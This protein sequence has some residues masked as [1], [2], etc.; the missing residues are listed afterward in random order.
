MQIKTFYFNPF[1]ECTYIISSNSGDAI[2][3]DCGC[4]TDKEKERVAN[5]ITEHGLTLI[6]H[7]LTHAHL[8]HTFGA[9]FI[10]E[11]YGLIPL[12]SQKDETILQ[13][14]AEQAFMFGCPLVEPPL[15]RFLPLEE[16][17]HF[18]CRPTPPTSLWSAFPTPG[19]TPGCVCYWFDADGENLL[20]TGD[21]LFAG[22]I[23]R[24][25]HPGGDYSVLLHSLPQLLTLPDDTKI[26]PGHGVA[27]TLAQEK[28]YNTY[29]Q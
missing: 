17:S 24:T 6:H 14:T 3:I 20:F 2:I 29:L 22:T 28:L 21:T 9:R 23:G 8:D 7:L 27:T 15:M 12:L 4:Y 26:F 25:D 19:H 13:H 1:R 11:K 5:Y 10:Y 18:F 16:D